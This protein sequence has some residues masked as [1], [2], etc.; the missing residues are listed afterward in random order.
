MK[1]YE[2]TVTLAGTGIDPDDAW[3]NAIEGFIDNPGSTPNKKDIKII[4][5]LDPCE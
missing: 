3:E 1:V 5:D 2:F 4:E